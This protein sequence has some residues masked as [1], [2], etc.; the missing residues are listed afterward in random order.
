MTEHSFQYITLCFDDLNEII[1]TRLVHLN[2]MNT[3]HTLKYTLVKYTIIYLV[4]V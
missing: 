1:T 2:N 4:I 3:L